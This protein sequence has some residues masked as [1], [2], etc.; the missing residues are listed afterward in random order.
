M[1]GFNECEECIY[2]NA[3]SPCPC[4]SCKQ[5]TPTKFKGFDLDE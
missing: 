3:I 4:D 5:N 2:L 1:N